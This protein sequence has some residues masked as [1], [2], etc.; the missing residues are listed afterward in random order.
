MCIIFV[1][2]HNVLFHL[3]CARFSEQLEFLTQ[4]IVHLL[5]YKI[6]VSVM[7]IAEVMIT[8]YDQCVEG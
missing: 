1:V 3:E 7:C 8:S 5:W 2:L 6:T 4:V